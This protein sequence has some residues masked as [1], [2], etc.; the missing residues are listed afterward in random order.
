MSISNRSKSLG[1]LSWLILSTQ[2]YCSFWWIFQYIWKFLWNSWNQFSKCHPCFLFLLWRCRILWPNLDCVE[3]SFATDFHH[4]FGN[5]EKHFE[6][7]CKFQSKL[8]LHWENFEWPWQSS[9][10][11]KLE[12]FHS[13]RIKKIEGWKWKTWFQWKMFWKNWFTFR[14]QSYTSLKI[15]VKK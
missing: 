7:I 14:A 2:H 13:P 9:L 4:N 1:G 5:M 3:L 12:V 11:T 15:D 8:P 6:S 10:C